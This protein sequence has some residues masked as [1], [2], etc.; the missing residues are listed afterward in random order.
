MHWQRLARRAAGV[1]IA[2]A[3]L[4]S[5]M[6]YGQSRDEAT[7]KVGAEALFEDGRRLVEAGK[8]AEARPKFAD[9]QRLD[10]SPST[11]LNLAN[12]LEKLGR[13]A[14][15]W[16]TYKE[17]GSLASAG[18]R[19]D[20]V[21]TADRHAN[22]LS[23]KLA[24]LIVNVPHAVDGMVVKRDA[25]VLEHSEWGTPI[26]IDAGPHVLI[27]T[28][29]GHASWISTVEIA[30]DGLEVSVVVPALE[31]VP[32]ATRPL[33]SAFSPP[34]A[35]Q[36]TPVA[37]AAEAAP[38]HLGDRQRI[39]GWV[40]GGAGVASLGVGA[41]FGAVAISKHNSSRD[42]MAGACDPDDATSCE[43][44]VVQERNDARNA[45]NIANWTLGAGA[46]GL[47]AGA[48]LWIT[49]PHGGRERRPVAGWFV[50][51]APGGAVLRGAW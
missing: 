32:D 38:S 15:A 37:A 21:E 8:Y 4:P 29:P 1:A 31:S 51:P 41:V 24:R 17:A 42:A 45:G 23:A 35:S 10:P 25:A 20:Y 28:A 48:V 49:A 36:P 14:S 11:L 26:P 44:E 22:A 2:F 46:A 30:Q 18:G 12:C 7:D 5:G 47:V 33:G 16:A 19:S 27:A 6:A 50:V 13:T 9:S 34:I 39:I 43:P 3:T 40:V